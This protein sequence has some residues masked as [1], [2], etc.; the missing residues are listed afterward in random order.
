MGPKT[1]PCGTPVLISGINEN[2]LVKVFCIIKSDMA[3]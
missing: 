2:I 3:T 1:D